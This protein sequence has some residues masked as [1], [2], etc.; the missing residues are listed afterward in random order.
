MVKMI[1]PPGVRD[2]SLLTFPSLCSWFCLAATTE[3]PTWVPEGSLSF[4]HNLGKNCSRPNSPELSKEQ[5]RAG[6]GNPIRMDKQHH[7]P[8]Q[9][10]KCRLSQGIL[11]GGLC[12]GSMHASE[13]LH[14]YHGTHRHPLTASADGTQQ[15]AGFSFCKVRQ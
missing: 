15:P 5:N 12:L 13:T 4:H 8:K 9:N 1:C 7:E 14:T 2:I 6:P 3:R 11:A 10:T